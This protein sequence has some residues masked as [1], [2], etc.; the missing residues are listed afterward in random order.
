MVIE[1][2]P[3]IQVVSQIGSQFGAVL[4]RRDSLF[5]ANFHIDICLS[6]AHFNHQ[7]LAGIASAVRLITSY[8]RCRAHPCFTFSALHI[9]E[10]PPS[11]CSDRWRHCNPV[12]RHHTAGSNPT[13]PAR[14]IST[15]G[16]PSIYSS[17]THR[18]L[19]AV[20]ALKPHYAQHQRVA[21]A[22]TTAPARR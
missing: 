17:S 19:R 7:R 1:E 16:F 4:L 22:R 6:L 5:C 21:S 9:P 10:S 14:P 11:Y 2:Q 8:S 20:F 12:E 13:F 18:P 15:G 3:D